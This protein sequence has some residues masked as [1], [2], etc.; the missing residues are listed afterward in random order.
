[1]EKS[2]SIKKVCGFYVSSVH[3]VTMLLP[4]LNKQ[5][6]EQIEVIPFLEFDLRKNVETILS[7]IVLN[8]KNKEQILDINWKNTKVQK[9]TN[10]EST[11]KEKL[12]NEKE[13]IILVS[14][15]KKYIKI[16]NEM[17][18]RYFNKYRNNK[19]YITVINCFEVEE[20]DDDIRDILY[21]HEYIINTSG[22]NKIEDVFEIYKEKQVNWHNT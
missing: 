13:A 12:K 5:I 3:L 10:I 14:G 15:S 7:K 11:I 19:K 2:N 22:I 21:E 18:E 17:I 16:V 9:F 1:M 8:E 20:F 6:E 4:Y